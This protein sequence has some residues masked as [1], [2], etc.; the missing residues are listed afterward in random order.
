LALLS[1]IYHEDFD[2]LRSRDRVRITYLDTYQGKLP[3]TVNG[4]TV[5]APLLCLHHF[6]NT[7]N[8]LNNGNPMDWMMEKMRTSFNGGKPVDHGL[9]NEDIQSVI[10]METPAILAQVRKILGL[11]K[12]ALIIPSDVHAFLMDQQLMTQDQF[13]TVRGGN[14]LDED[15]FNSFIMALVKGASKADSLP[16][17]DSNRKTAATLFFH[18]HVICILMLQRGGGTVW[19]DLI[20]SLPSRRTFERLDGSSSGDSG[21]NNNTSNHSDDF[22]SA[23]SDDLSYAL[24]LSERTQY[25]EAHPDAFLPINN[26]NEQ[27]G[28]VRIRCTDEESLRTALRWFACSKFTPENQSYINAYPWEDNKS[29]FDPRVFQAFIWREA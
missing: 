18:E 26:M 2:A 5:I 12:D 24:A 14:I 4:C 1:S 25:M 19:Y 16:D 21:G 10:D 7:E 11:T 29:D 8:N 3:T 9:S 22:F 28:A 13:V 6:H 17:H 15:H 23:R 20:D 27:L